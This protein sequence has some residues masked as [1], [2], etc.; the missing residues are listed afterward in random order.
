VRAFVRAYTDARGQAANPKYVTL[1]PGY[2]H[3]Q[4][5]ARAL[6]RWDESE[7]ARIG[8]WNLLAA[9]YIAR[10]R[11]AQQIAA[12]PLNNCPQDANHKVE[13]IEIVENLNELLQIR[14][15]MDILAQ[16]QTMANDIEEMATGRDS[17]LY[18]LAK[19]A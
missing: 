4:A 16:H 9:V 2:T 12:Y 14:T 17:R 11:I 10:I 8:R 3:E 5:C 18:N 15:G 1:K 6:I 13:N 19:D 7:C